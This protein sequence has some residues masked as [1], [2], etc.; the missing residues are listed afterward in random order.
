[1][2]FQFNS[3]WIFFS[4][5]FQI[6]FI[7]VSLMLVK[8]ETLLNTF[9][10][11]TIYLYNVRVAFSPRMQHYK[12]AAGTERSLVYPSETGFNSKLVFS[13]LVFNLAEHPTLL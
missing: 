3:G 8:S 7:P 5:K 1:M 9:I 12:L 13:K 2:I 11:E 6:I 10:M 4:P